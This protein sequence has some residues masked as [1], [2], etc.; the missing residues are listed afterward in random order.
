MEL[1][2]ALHEDTDGF[3]LADVGDEELEKALDEACLETKLA[4]R[5]TVDHLFYVEFEDPNSPPKGQLLEEVIF[6]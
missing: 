1:Q 4:L 5:P 3:Y 6:N 2:H